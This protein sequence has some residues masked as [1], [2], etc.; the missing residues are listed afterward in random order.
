[1]KIVYAILIV[2]AALIALVLIIALF[3]KKEYTVEREVTINKP[4]PEVFDYVSRIKKQVEFNV[5]VQADPNLKQEFIGTDGTVGFINKWNGNKKAG[6]GEQEITGL[7]PNERL[8]MALRFKRPMESKATAYFITKEA[9]NNS[10]VVT[11]GMNGRSP[12]PM[13]FM[14]LFIDSMLGMDMETSLNNLKNNI[15]K[16]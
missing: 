11:W 9:G 2:I 8:D 1:M 6:E 13:N 10:T 4:V 3:V 14:N 7:V 12:Y 15:E 16:Q 5:W